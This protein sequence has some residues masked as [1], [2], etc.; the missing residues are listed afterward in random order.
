MLKG[1]SFILNNVR[2]IQPVLIFIFY[3]FMEF[4][5]WLP[6]R[7]WKI[8]GGGN[9]ID[10]SQILAFSDCNKELGLKIYESGI[11]PCHNYLYGR[12]LIQSLNFLNIGIEFT[13]I[14][15]IIF[16]L[17]L[18]I[19]LSLVLPWQ[20]RQ[21]TIYSILVLLSP[22]FLLLAE[23]GNFDILMIAGLFLASFFISRKKYIASAL[24]IF[25]LSLIKFYTVPLLLVLAVLSRNL[26]SRF[27][28][29]LLF[30]LASVA[31]LRDLRLIG[32]GFP[33]GS[34]AEFG[35]QIWY[36]Y[37]LEWSPMS[38]PS[39]YG[40]LIC[41]ILFFIL[42][43][44]FLIMTKNESLPKFL[45]FDL[46]SRKFSDVLNFLFAVTLVV[47]FI[48]GMNFDY[49]LALLIPLISH[50]ISLGGAKQNRIQFFFLGILWL[51]YPSGGLQVFG[52]VAIELLAALLFTVL[53]R[54]TW[55]YARSQRKSHLNPRV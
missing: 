6:L 38:F 18:S 1:K 9:F 2:W 32:N 21:K 11:G 5:T 45:D 27:I 19:C 24:V 49:R 39:T 8:W 7:F 52:D 50:Q 12:F 42:C 30:V 10:I 41:L 51:S 23:R 20:G 43:V 29:L 22:P 26:W 48:F 17:I 40:K 25:A 46:E 35:A 14:F 34:G 47:C 3:I 37:F 16:L 54:S 13:R 55:R 28:S 36:E 4:T 53:I 15:G 33:H 31:I 44:F